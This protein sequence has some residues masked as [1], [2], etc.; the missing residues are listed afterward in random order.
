MLDD[1]GSSISSSDVSNIASASM[2]EF[3]TFGDDGTDV[4]LIVGIVFGVVGGI[5]VISL[6]VLMIVT[7]TKKK[8]A[9]SVETG[10]EMDSVNRGED[11][12][13]YTKN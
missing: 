11:N 9:G 3:P 5:A 1:Q 7:K 10:A 6:I 12:T 4:G 13:A 8:K 2:A